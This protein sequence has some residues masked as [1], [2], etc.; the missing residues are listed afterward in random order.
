MSD[1]REDIIA[2]AAPIFDERGGHV[3][4]V[5]DDEA[6]SIFAASERPYAKLKT[7]QG[8]STRVAGPYRRAYVVTRWQ[9]EG[10]AA[11]AVRHRDYVLHIRRPRTQAQASEGRA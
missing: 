3:P 4:V 6:G 2:A 10:G 11:F 7:A 9:E 8:V 1:W 5:L